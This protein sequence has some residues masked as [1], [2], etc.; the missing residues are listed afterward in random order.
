MLL[1]QKL[2]KAS[3][4]AIT[5]AGVQ[6]WSSKNYS[7]SIILI[8]STII[9]FLNNNLLLGV[10]SFLPLIRTRTSGNCSDPR[11]IYYTSYIAT[12]LYCR[13][14]YFLH[15]FMPR[16]FFPASIWPSSMV[17]R[18][19]HKYISLFLAYDRARAHLRVHMDAGIKC[20]VII[21][22]A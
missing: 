19:D 12:R 7:F 9:S 8:L 15:S 17:Y 10:V 18:S 14:P 6:K 11:Y 2:S 20:I 22:S 16:K 13:A 5:A 4:R 3:N 21:R 1:T